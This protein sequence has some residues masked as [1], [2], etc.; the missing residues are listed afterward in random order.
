MKRKSSNIDK[1]DDTDKSDFETILNFTIDDKQALVK[2]WPRF[3]TL[4]EANTLYQ[5]LYSLKSKYFTQDIVKMMG[6]DILAPRLTA[7]FGELGIQCG[8]PTSSES[9]GIS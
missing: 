1:S 5:E 4:D 2:Y 8:V 6:K 7:A 3:L 9:S